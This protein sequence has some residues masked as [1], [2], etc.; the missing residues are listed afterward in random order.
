MAGSGTPIGTPNQP[1]SYGEGNNIAAV[2]IKAI[3]DLTNQIVQNRKQAFGDAA[4]RE[5][6]NLDFAWRQNVQHEY[7]KKL[8]EHETAQHLQRTVNETSAHIYNS[9]EQANINLSLLRRVKA[10]GG[11]DQF[12]HSDSGFSAQLTKPKTTRASRAKAPLADST[13]VTTPVGGT[14]KPA[15]K[16]T[17]A[18]P[19]G[20]A[21]P[22]LTPAQK[23]AATRKAKAEA[24]AKAAP[25]TTKRPAKTTPVAEPTPP[26]AP[27]KRTP[28]P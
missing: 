25:S 2:G 22:Q 1:F 3:G 13:K 7:A 20:Q 8:M 6:D 15:A 26:R 18:K 9:R 21:A 4:K 10:I 17:T 11:V 16:A 14:A 5:N 19:A 24:A 28:K 12:A 23:A 27:R